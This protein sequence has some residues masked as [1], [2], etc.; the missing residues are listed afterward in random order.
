VD[1]IVLPPL[2]PEGQDWSAAVRLRDQVRAA[3]LNAC[4]EPDLA[5]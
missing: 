2:T 1:V 5:Q 4:G 3:V